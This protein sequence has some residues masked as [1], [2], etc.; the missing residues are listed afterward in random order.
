[1]KHRADAPKGASR[2]RCFRLPY[3]NLG[4]YLS[5]YTPPEYFF[6]DITAK[7]GRKHSNFRLNQCY[8]S[9]RAV[10]SRSNEGDEVTVSIRSLLDVSSGRKNLRSTNAEILSVFG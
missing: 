5:V 7:I 9:E 3:C 6:Q 2:C 10:A 8:N 1:M 4:I